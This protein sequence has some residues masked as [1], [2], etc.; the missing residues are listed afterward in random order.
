MTSYTSHL[1]ANAGYCADRTTYPDG[2]YALSSKLAES[3]TVIPY[4]TSSM[5]IYRYGAYARNY[6]SAQTPTLG[7]PRGIVDTYSTTTASGGNGQLTYPVALIT[8]DEASFAGSGSS[9]ATNGSSYNANSFLRSGSSFWLLSPYFRDSVGYA[10]VFFL[11]SNGYLGGNG[12][13]SAYGAS[14]HFPR[15]WNDDQWW[16]WHRS[17][18]LDCNMVKE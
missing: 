8:A 7:C 16:R 12:V 1:E 9:T 5:T 18:S 17:K 14:G 10:S 13:N 2:S 6:N 4:G 15:L 11:G 3:T